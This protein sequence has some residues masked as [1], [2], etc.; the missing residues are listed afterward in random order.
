M[1]EAKLVVKRHPTHL[2]HFE[3]PLVPNTRLQRDFF[4]ALISWAGREIEHQSRP[5]DCF[6]IIIEEDIQASSVVHLP[7]AAY[8][9]ADILEGIPHAKM[10]LAVIAKFFR[11][12]CFYVN[13]V[14][15]T[16]FS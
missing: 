13:T 8:E 11:N 16:G 12:L 7:S 10:M 9:A 2:G 5:D 3:E 6:E 4:E 15:H 14:P 1:L